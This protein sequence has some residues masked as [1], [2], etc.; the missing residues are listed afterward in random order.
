[1]NTTRLRLGVHRAQHVV[2]ERLPTL[3]RVRPGLAGA[4]G[5]GR[6]EQQHALASPTPRGCRAAATAMPRSDCSSLQMLTSDGGGGTP[7]RTEK[8]SPCAWSGPWYGSWP[9]M[10]TAVSAYDVRCSARN[11]SAPAGRP[12]VRSRSAA[13]NACSSLQYGLANSARS[14]GFQSVVGTA[15]SCAIDRAPL[16]SPAMSTDRD[17]VLAIDI[18]GTKFAAGLMTM[19]RRADR[20]HARPGRPRRSTRS[21][22][23]TRS[24]SSCRT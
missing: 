24:P 8:H 13:T 1:M 9:R 21:T 17:V 2:G 11:T 12:C 15:T 16:P 18:G 4:H 6:V 5:E 20:P 22:C 10:T 3:A 14:T 7:R 23:S 19:T